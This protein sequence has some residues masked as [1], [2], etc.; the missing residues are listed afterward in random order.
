MERRGGSPASTSTS[1]NLIVFDFDLTIL[2]IHSW[3]ERIAPRDVP[4]R[5]LEEDVADLEFFRA[6][7]GRALDKGIEIAIASFG[8]Y[9]VIQGYMDRAVGPGVFTRE[10]ISTPSQHGTKDGFVVQG[11][12]VPQLRSLTSRLLKVPPGEVPAAASGVLFFDDS[13]ENIEAALQAGFTHSV[14]TKQFFTRHLWDE[15][16]GT[17]GMEDFLS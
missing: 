10:N 15:V 4:F 2:N 17:L 6:F 9:E 11:G 8:M 13:S 5:N 16:K 3:S 12:K 1:I 14:S 7:V